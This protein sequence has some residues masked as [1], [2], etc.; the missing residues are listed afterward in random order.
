MPKLPHLLKAL[1]LI[2]LA[3]FLGLGFWYYTQTNSLAQVV[4]SGSPL[5]QDSG[6]TQ[7]LLLGI[8]GE[9]HQGAELTDSI[10]LLS[11]SHQDYSLKTLSIPRDIWS[12]PL[13]AKINTA[14]YYGGLELA[15][16]TISEL[17]KTPIHYS[18]VL[19]FEGFVQ[20]IDIVGGIDLVVQQS[21]VDHKYP[22]PGKENA[23][24]AES[25]YE[26]LSFDKGPLHLNG[27]MALKFAR[28]RYAEGEEGTDFA[29]GKRQQLV[30]TA[31]KD[32]LVSTETLLNLETIK[33]IIQS[34]DQSI[35]TDIKEDLYLSFLRWG[36]SFIR[37]GSVI[38][39]G[40]LTDYLIHPKST[41]PYGGAWVLIPNQNFDP[42]V[43]EFLAQ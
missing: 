33:S 6:S 2:F 42:Y 3:F 21:F 14:Y 36:T 40:N 43:Q 20:L 1:G 19:D 8:G 13:K 17:L 35:T 27:E 26:S 16:K 9:N 29:R 24:P 11:L 37:A 23:E 30:I 31:L 18:L 10:M 41:A 39:P 5:A 38:I 25:R 15:T 4:F 28:S 22:I 7:V 12:E 32:K 34:L